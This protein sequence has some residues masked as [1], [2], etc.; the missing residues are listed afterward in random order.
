MLYI[1][2]FIFHAFYDICIYVY[3][4]IYRY[5]NIFVWWGCQIG[6]HL[7]L[8]HWSDHCPAKL[9]HGL[10]MS[11]PTRCCHR[12]LSQAA[13]TGCCQKASTKRDSQAQQGSSKVRPKTKSNKR[14]RESNSK[15]GHKRNRAQAR[16]GRNENSEAEQGS[17]K[18]GPKQIKQTQ[19]EP[20]WI[21]AQRLLS[22]LTIPGFS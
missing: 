16:L 4:Y 9:N 21:V 3:I 10:G 20:Q 22:A 7:W 1:I 15:R 2:Y 19:D 13:A 12:L 5:I 6:V 18:V 11:E 8:H 14:S 17:S